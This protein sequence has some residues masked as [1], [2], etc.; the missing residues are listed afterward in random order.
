MLVRAVAPESARRPEKVAP[1][2]EGVEERKLVPSTP[3]R[4]LVNWQSYKKKKSFAS[5]SD[6]KRASIC[7]HCIML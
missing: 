4:E 1:S 5:W 7:Q 3:D 6:R 2:F